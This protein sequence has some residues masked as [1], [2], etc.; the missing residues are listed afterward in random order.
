MRDFQKKLHEVAPEEVKRDIIKQERVI[1]HTI[2]MVM[3]RHEYFKKADAVRFQEK[4]HVRIDQMA[5]DYRTWK[6]AGC[7]GYA[8]PKQYVSG[9]VAGASKKAFDLMLNS[10]LIRAQEIEPEKKTSDELS[11]LSLRAK[12]DDD[13]YPEC[14]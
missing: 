3:G 6:R 10:Y 1:K 8:K 12:K 9:R 13:L 14:A 7:K 4:F 5:A 11:K 2:Y